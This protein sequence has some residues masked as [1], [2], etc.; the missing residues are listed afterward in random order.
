ML[1]TRAV[2]PSPTIGSALDANDGLGPGF[3]TLRVVLS[4]S[5]ILWHCFPLTQGSSDPI[6][7]TWGWALAYPI[8]P[9]FFAL[10][11]FLV[12]G[13]AL[14]L[15]LRN[16]ALARGL[17]IVP[18]LAV[19]TLV[20]ILIIGPLFTTMPLSEFYSDPETHRYLLNIVGE[21]HYELPGVFLDNPY[22]DV[23]N[24]SLWTIAP[25]L[26]CYLAMGILIALGWAKNWRLTLLFTLLAFVI[27]VVA[28][29]SETI[30][31][32]PV[33]RRASMPG[34]KL[35]PFFLLGSLAYL[36]RHRIPL[37]LKGF[38]IAF[39]V[40]PVAALF[41]SRDWWEN[42]F[43]VVLSA[44]FLTYLVIA[45]GMMKLPKLP[46]FDRGDYSY[47]V[48]LYGFPIQQGIIAIFGTMAP[49]TL[50]V[51][52][53]PVV[54]LLAMFSWHVV[55]KPTLRLRKLLAKK[56]VSPMPAVYQES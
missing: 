56:P 51:F 3:D 12:T 53:I 17:R 55:E 19:D 13:S 50:F 46:I 31:N 6:K 33:I 24:G 16:F 14:R 43:W 9:M 8:I 47:G 4:F 5:V 35:I 44:P 22:P 29:Y 7:E 37:S 54:L 20:T 23:V 42:P 27:V 41:G 49:L 36:L 25:E 52:T 38:W 2:K 1:V 21:I 40:I 32:T 48:Y 45:F 18:A 26:G 39:A 28:M 10:S 11:G 15:T 30:Q 34:G